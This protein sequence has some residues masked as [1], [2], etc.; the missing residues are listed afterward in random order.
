MGNSDRGEMPSDTLEFSMCK[1]RA[2][3]LIKGVG[4]EGTLNII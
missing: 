4:M 2:F 3:I 1:Q